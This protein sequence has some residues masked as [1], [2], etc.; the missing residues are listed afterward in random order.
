M[1]SPFIGMNP[2][3]ETR[4]TWASV[5]LQLIA[6]FIRQ[7]APQV[8]PKYRVN[9]ER[10]LKINDFRGKYRP[11]LYLAK[12]PAIGGIQPSPAVVTQASVIT[13]NLPY[14]EKLDIPP[15]LEIVTVEGEVVTVIEVLSYINK[16]DDYHSY[17]NKRYE[18]LKADVNLLEIDLLRAGK[19]V[20][21]AAEVDSPY[22]CILNRAREWPQSYGWEV[23][24]TTPLPI[25]PVPLH[26]SD[27]EVSLQLAPALTQIYET[28][29]EG[30]VDYT[31]DP[32][33]KLTP[34]WQEELE[35]LLRGKGLRG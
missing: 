31:A 14:E 15:H 25:L 5:H 27:P 8:R 30:F 12:P 10:Y 26:A 24:W 21:L 1:A 23:S 35:A 28:Q 19:R 29:F 6:D 9:A 16:E 22:S 33:E 7:L 3:M 2:Y 13:Q 18:I 34:A 17:V 11:D 32:P 4:A 20:P